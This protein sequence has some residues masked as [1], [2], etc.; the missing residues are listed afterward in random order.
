MVKIFM[1]FNLPAMPEDAFEPLYAEFDQDNFGYI[2]VE[3][4]HSLSAQIANKI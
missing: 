2:T 4:W 3:Q 1:H